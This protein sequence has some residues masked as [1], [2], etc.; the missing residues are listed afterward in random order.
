MVPINVKL[1]RGDSVLSLKNKLYK[2][3]ISYNLFSNSLYC[4]SSNSFSASDVTLSFLALVGDGGVPFL[5]KLY[6]FESFIPFR[7]MCSI[8]LSIMLLIIFFLIL[9]V[10]LCFSPCSR[11]SKR[12]NKGV[13]G[14]VLM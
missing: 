2:Y 8:A 11:E 7:A 3:T 10:N 1:L 4:A 13:S 5:V 9:M 6:S 14:L 12:E